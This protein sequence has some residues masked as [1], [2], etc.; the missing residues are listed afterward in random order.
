MQEAIE[1]RL[2]ELREEY[3]AG[4]QKLAE[5]DSQRNT[6]R[7]TMLRISGAIQALEEM[8]AIDSGSQSTEIASPQTVEEAA[9]R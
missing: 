3:Q 5:L 1:R 6:V 2:R 7:D 4:Q 8:S 9:A